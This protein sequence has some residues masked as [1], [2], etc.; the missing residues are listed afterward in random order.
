VAGLVCLKPGARDHLLYRM[1]LHGRQKGKRRGMS[2][3]DYAGMIAAAHHQLQA[4][5]R[6]LGQP[7]HACQHRDA[8]VHR[9]ASGLADVSLTT[10]ASA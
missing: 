2:E 4:A 8:R 7:E 5:D 3:A 10:A 9:S 1:G 6:D